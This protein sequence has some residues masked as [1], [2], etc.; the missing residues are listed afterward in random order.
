MLKFYVTFLLLILLIVSPLTAQAKLNVFACEPEWQSLANEIG[1][2]DINA[3]SATSAKQDPHHIRAKPSLIAKMRKADLLI[4]SGADLEIGW[5]PILLQN[6]NSDIQP[7]KIGYFM[8][9]DVLQLLEKP[10]VLDRARGDIHAHGN[11]HSHLNPYNILL[12]AKELNNRLKAIDSNNA[13]NYQTRYDDFVKKWQNSLKVW[14]AKAVKLRNSAIVVHH[15][16]FSYLIDWL[17]LKEVATLEAKPGISPTVSH[18]KS[19]LQGLRK[20]PAKLIIRTPYDS[21]D[22]SNWLSEKTGIKAIQL[23]YTVG[24]DD[25][26]NNL[27]TLYEQTINLMINS[28]DN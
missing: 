7:G 25:K 5:L 13:Q 4:C 3:F 21:D 24:G 22:A 18:L 27:F 6:A 19:L 20:K 1:G 23:P 26:S 9:S 15:K 28:Y 11:P 14:E 2:D 10:T 16:S 8:T 12:V 17:E